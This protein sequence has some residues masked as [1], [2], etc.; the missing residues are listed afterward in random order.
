MLDQESGMDAEGIPAIDSYYT[1]FIQRG[2]KKC[3]HSLIVNI[4]GTK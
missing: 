1:R 2:P 3:T 4:S